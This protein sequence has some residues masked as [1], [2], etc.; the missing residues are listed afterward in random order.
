MRPGGRQRLGHPRPG[1]T[2]K[3]TAAARAEQAE[4]KHGRGAGRAHG[5]RTRVPRRRAA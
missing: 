4:V 2:P 5:G 1:C 3:D